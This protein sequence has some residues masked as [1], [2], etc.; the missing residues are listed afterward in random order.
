M[1][2]I[3]LCGHSAQWKAASTNIKNFFAF[4]G[5]HPVFEVPFEFDYFIHTFDASSSD[6]K[7]MVAEYNPKTGVSSV[8]EKCNFPNADDPMFYS[9]ERCVMLKQEYELNNDMQY[10][11]VVKANLDTIYDPMYKFPIERILPKHC[12][13]T[14]IKALPGD[15]NYFAFD[16]TLFYGDSPTMDLVAD[17]YGSPRAHYYTPGCMLY[18]HLINSAIHPVERILK[19]TT[20]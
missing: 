3:C 4:T 5:N 9:F 6:I 2:A 1:V 13:T 18:N 20:E 16:D 7:D 15:F 17:L 8:E 12:Y 14:S 19:E 10:D 11:I